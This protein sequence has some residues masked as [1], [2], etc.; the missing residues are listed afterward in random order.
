MVVPE[1]SHRSHTHLSLFFRVCQKPAHN[2][3]S[4]QSPVLYVGTIIP[5]SP[6]TTLDCAVTVSGDAQN[7][8]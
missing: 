4:H 6:E 3:S 7:K 8:K 1:L 5:T 2:L